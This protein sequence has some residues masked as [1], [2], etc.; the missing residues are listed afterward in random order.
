MGIALSTLNALPQHFCRLWL[1]LHPRQLASDHQASSQDAPS[2][3]VVSTRRSDGSDGCSPYPSAADGILS[4]PPA[5][6]HV[7][8]PLLQVQTPARSRWPFTVPP[9]PGPT[10]TPSKAT[11][12]VR[13]L[14][15][16]SGGGRRAACVSAVG[17]DAHICHASRGVR[18]FS[19]PG[20][21]RLSISG[22]M[23]DVCAELDRLAAFEAL[24][25]H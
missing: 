8:V 7:P 18:R 23:G 3:P 15:G 11:S 17:A 4:A 14:Q 25:V 21:A 10:P 16:R 22:R 19:E 6:L 20:S 9:T 1:W 2:Q 24:Q 13:S 12:P 5:S